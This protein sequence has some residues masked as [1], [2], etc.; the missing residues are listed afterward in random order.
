MRIL[1]L[2]LAAAAGA[3]VAAA[4]VHPA[5]AVLV[6]ANGSFG[7]IP[8]GT[9]TVNTGD[10]SAFTAFK[11]LPS[12]ETVN[13]I[14]DP[15]M[16]SPNNLGLTLGESVAVSPLTI[17][18]PPVGPPVVLGTPV[19]IAVATTAGPSG[20]LTFT[21]T[22]EQTLALTGVP[23]GNISLLFEGTLTGDTSGTFVTGPTALADLSE[24]C[25]QAAAGGSINCSDTVDI[26]PTRQFIPEPASLALLGSA[27]LGF[28]LFRRRQRREAA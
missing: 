12:A 20:T 26:P 11:T 2:T 4:A 13:T 25:T 14:K 9:V 24:S 3:L 23:G 19:T 22:A 27:L 15:F 21:Y 10:I 7:F 6:N 17:P 16:G 1:G 18:V 28:G 5:Q 8:L